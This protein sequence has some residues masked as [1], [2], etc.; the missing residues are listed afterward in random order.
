[1]FS[2]WFF[3][4]LNFRGIR[5]FANRLSSLPTGYFKVGLNIGDIRLY[6]NSLDRFLAIIFWKLSLLEGFESKYLLK[7]IRPGWTILDIGANIGFYTIQFAKAVNKNGIVFAV[8]PANN[9]IDMLKKNI[10]INEVKNVR[11]INKAISSKTD[12]GELFLSEG[13]SGDHR[14]YETNEKRESVIVNTITVDAI[15]NNEKRVDLI[16]MDIQGA[17]HLAIQGMNETIDRFPNIIIV[18]EFSPSM[19][20]SSG[21]NPIKFVQY[22]VDKGFKIKFFDEKKKSLQSTN[23]EAL[24]NQICIYDRYVSLFL[25]R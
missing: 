12:S 6:A 7:I 23:I 11:I 17:E 19:L 2:E 10:E 3:R 20:N 5:H 13:H 8:E 16:K 25:K 1:M 18:T 21:G 22:F 15:V 14:I 4:L 9:N 24:M